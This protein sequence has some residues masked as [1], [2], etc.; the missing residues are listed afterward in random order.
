MLYAIVESGGKQYKAVEGAYIDLDLLPDNLGERKSLDKILLLVNGDQ[1]E[2]GN[3]FVPKV[4]V[5]TIVFEHFKGPKITVFKYRPRQRYRVKTGH[6]QKYTRVLV[7]SIIFPGKDDASSKKQSSESEISAMPVRKTRS[8]PSAS[9]K[10]AKKSTVQPKS[11]ATSKI[12][13][14]EKKVKKEEVKFPSNKSIEE[15]ELG[16]R[17]TSALVDAG[18]KKIMVLPFLIATGQHVKEDIPNELAALR[19]KYP[20]VEMDLGKPLGA[21]SRLAEILIERAAE[22]ERSN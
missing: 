7:D 4:V 15:L 10:S 22:M 3:P 19:E 13:A 21:D 5:E 14:A 18:I 11:T 2:V 6:R 9:K 12:S 20:G 17:T 8:K 16:A 1:Q